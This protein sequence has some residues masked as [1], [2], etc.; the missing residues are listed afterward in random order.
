MYSFRQLNEKGTFFGISI[1]DFI[2]VVVL[3][4]GFFHFFEM[5][6]FPEI[7]NVF[8][9][10]LMLCFLIPLRLTCRRKTIRD[11]VYC[12]LTPRCIYDPKKF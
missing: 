4:V 5:V 10:M 2:G 9:L 8:L 7:A 12:L 6:N 3:F 1:N 11:I